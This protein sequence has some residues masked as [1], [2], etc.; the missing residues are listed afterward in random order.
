MHA[1]VVKFQIK[2]G[3]RDEVIRLFEEFVVP[4]AKKQ[5]GFLGG[6][7]LTDPHMN[8][9]TSI[10]LWKT[11]A[12]IKASE[13]SGYYK[14]WFAELSDLLSR[15]PSREIFEMSHLVNLQIK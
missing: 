10:S 12:D 2:P 9:A 4:G 3:K 14:G 1:K 7:L 15:V 11:E 8:Y 6:M 5:K 13:A